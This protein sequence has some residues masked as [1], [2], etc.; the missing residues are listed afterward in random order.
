VIEHGGITLSPRGVERLEMTRP[1]GC[2]ELLVHTVD[3]GRIIT[4]EGESGPV[5]A[6]GG[7]LPI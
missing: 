3:V 5:T 1:P 7:R 4:K 2:G 6:A